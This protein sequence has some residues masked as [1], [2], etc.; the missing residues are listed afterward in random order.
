[1]SD[2]LK[3]ILTDVLYSAVTLLLAAFLFFAP[4]KEFSLS[5]RRELASFPSVSAANIKSGKF[6]SEFEDYTLDQFPLRDV[7]RSVKAYASKYIFLQKSNN[8]IY[9]AD[10]VA[11]KIE[12]PV[13][14]GSLSYASEK[15]RYIYDNYLTDCKV[16]LSVIPDKNAFLAKE[17]GQ[18]SMDYGKFYSLVESSADFADFIKIDHLLSADDYY[19]SDTHWKAENIADVASA[20]AESMGTSVSDDISFRD[21]G[22]SF[23]GVYS[24]QSALP[25]KTDHLYAA[26]SPMLENCTVFDH[27]N[28]REISLYDTEKAHGKDPYEMY[29]SGPL[30]LITIDNPNVKN[31]R[32]LIIFRD[33][34]ASSLAPILS[35]AYSHITLVDIRYLPSSQLYRHIDFDGCDVLF[36][37]STSVLNN[38]NTLK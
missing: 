20:L 23:S 30:S 38:S 16:Y 1:M 25:L 36:L 32:K 21:T 15:F 7:F 2:R 9:V 28:N 35:T 11:S 10:G 37:Y 27:Q 19:A 14:H 6:M 17:N 12:Y 26:E 24:G 29:L 22:I 13:N 5:E 4:A 34:F 33:S 31:G 8:G 18:L 3:N